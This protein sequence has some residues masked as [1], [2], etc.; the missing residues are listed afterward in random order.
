M[1]LQLREK[2]TDKQQT[3]R[4]KGNA[5]TP[6]NQKNTYLSN[7]LKLVC[8]RKRNPLEGLYQNAWLPI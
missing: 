8:H 3:Y 7:I 2:T 5:G 6:T 1:T 4:K